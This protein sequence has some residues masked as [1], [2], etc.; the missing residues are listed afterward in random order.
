M[1]IDV[2]YLTCDGE[3]EMREAG[4]GKGWCIIR[5]RP[6]AHLFG[7]VV[8]PRPNLVGKVLKPDQLTMR[9]PSFLLLDPRGA[10]NV[11]EK[12]ASPE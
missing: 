8:G 7:P 11:R 6:C 3:C 4:S 10:Q 5:K 9:V 1:G 2:P 12:R